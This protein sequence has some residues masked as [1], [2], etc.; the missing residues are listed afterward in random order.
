MASFHPSLEKTPLLICLN[1]DVAGD[2]GAKLLEIS[3]IANVREMAS[4]MTSVRKTAVEG[5]YR[6]SPSGG[7]IRE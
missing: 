4:L 2:I 3:Y 5:K 1:I 7:I 6:W